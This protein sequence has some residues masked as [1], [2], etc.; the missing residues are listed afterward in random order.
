MPIG[1]G[2]RPGAVRS[3]TMSYSI[4]R[5]T[6]SPAT[7]SPAPNWTAARATRR[8]GPCPSV[9]DVSSCNELAVDVD[10][11]GADAG[12]AEEDL[13]GRVRRVVRGQLEQAAAA[14]GA[15]P[16]NHTSAVARRSSPNSSAPSASRNRTRQPGSPVTG[17]VIVDERQ[18]GD[19]LLHDRAD[20]VADVGVR[21]RGADAVERSDDPLRQDRGAAAA[22]G[23]GLAALWPITAT[24]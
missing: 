10:P 20:R 5:S 2:Q 14:I 9:C 24:R 1:E 23:A 13:A 19:A 17:L 7:T 18:L 16:P 21:Q 15:S 11:G 4:R 3:C 8:R 6:G 22:L 12:E